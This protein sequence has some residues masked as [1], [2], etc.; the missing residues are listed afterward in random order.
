MSSATDN[1]IESLETRC[2]FAARAPDAGSG[3]LI[4]NATSWNDQIVIAQTADHQ[5]VRVTINGR[6]YDYPIG[7]VKRLI[8]DARNGH[9]RVTVDESHGKIVCGMTLS[10]GDGNDTLI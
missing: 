7:D 3:W 9:D 8:V 10:G 1:L 6:K 5:S 4:V 2:M